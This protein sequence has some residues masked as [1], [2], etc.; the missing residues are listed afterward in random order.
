MVFGK[1]DHVCLLKKSLYGLKQSPRQWYLRFDSFMITHAFNRCSY[2]CCVY[3]KKISGGRM[4]YLLVHVD[5]ML[6][7]CHDKKENDHL[8]KLLSREFEMKELGEPKRILGWIL[9]GIRVRR[10]CF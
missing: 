8:K 2:N 6:I 7:T 3:F 10:F 5:D 1:E 9:S 4:I